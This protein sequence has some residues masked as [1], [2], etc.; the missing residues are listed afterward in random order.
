M[1]YRKGANRSSVAREFRGRKSR[2]R[3]A[4]VMVMRGGY[5]L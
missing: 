5:R 4:N 1:M 2:T 3:R